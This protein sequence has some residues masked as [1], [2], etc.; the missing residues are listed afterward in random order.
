M[1]G[2]K[3]VRVWGCV[4]R[5]KGGLFDFCPPYGQNGNR[6]KVALVSLNRNG[7]QMKMQSFA[8]SLI[9]SLVPGYLVV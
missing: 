8:R 5:R 3:G 6:D 4:E 7:Q 1:E 2:E 9:H